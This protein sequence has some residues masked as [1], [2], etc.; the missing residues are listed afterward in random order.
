MQ[1]TLHLVFTRTWW[2]YDSA[3]DWYA[4]PYHWLNL[5]EG[6]LWM[7]FAGLVMRRYLRHRQSPLELLYSLLFVTFGLSDYLEAYR[8]QSWLILFKGANLAALLYFRSLVIRRFYPHSR[9]Y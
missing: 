2:D 6:S 5:V 3:A 8:L 9:V 4:Q 7:V 1:D